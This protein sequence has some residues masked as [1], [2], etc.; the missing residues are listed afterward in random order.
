M[1]DRADRHAYG[2]SL[3]CIG[4]RHFVM[5]ACLALAILSAMRLNGIIR[6]SYLLDELVYGET[7]SGR[8]ITSCVGTEC[9][10]VWSCYGQRETTEHILSPWMPLTGIFFYTLGFL[11]AF[12]CVRWQ[13]RTFAHYAFFAG[14]V[15]LGC[16]IFD[17]LFYATCDAYTANTIHATLTKAFPPSPITSAAR[18][19][20]KEL[21][22]FPKHEVD[23]ITN[24]F[25]VV[26]WYSIVFGLLTALILY[27][28][29]EAYGFEKL[30]GQG[31]LGLGVHY[32]LDQWDEYVDHDAVRRGRSKDMASK[33]IEDA[34]LPFYS[35][36]GIVKPPFGFQPTTLVHTMHYG[37]T[38]QISAEE[39]TPILD[40]LKVRQME[41]AVPLQEPVE[42]PEAV[43][44]PE[45]EK[46]IEELKLEEQRRFMAEAA[47]FQEAFANTVKDDYEYQAE[48]NGDAIK[49]EW[50]TVTET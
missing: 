28:A 13:V 2:T 21:Q 26:L 12:H 50:S 3:G 38:K 16:M 25:N 24:G 46:S 29:V 45:E 31:P 41:E 32:G 49:M 15:Q 9:Y 17:L 39:L 36:P 34:K 30:V 40:E 11:G 22:S 42:E 20:L 19:E 47:A 4:Q 44:P 27:L 6:G 37:A 7:D 5:V 1:G 18:E 35:H 33:F 48:E 23:D 10:E 8:V 14:L 43:P